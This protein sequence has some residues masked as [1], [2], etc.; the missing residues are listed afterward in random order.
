MKFKRIFL[1]L[2]LASCVFAQNPQQT[3]QQYKT[4][5]EAGWSSGKLQIAKAYY[6]S[7]DA[8]AFMAIYDGNVLVSWGEVSR[9]FMCHSIRKS[10]LSGL[11]GVY[12]A[13]GKID[14]DKTLADL[15]ID[16][17]DKL[18]DVEKQAK[19]RDLLKARSGVY[20]S[21]AYETAGMRR[22]RPKRDS[23]PPNTFWYY[24]NWDFNTAGAIFEKET[25]TDIFVAFKNRI[26][27]PLQM[28]DYRVSDGY[29]H[30]EAHNSIYPAYPFRMSAQDMARYGL[31]F[32]RAGR[33]NDEQIIS[34]EWIK[35]STTSYSEASEGGYG[36]MWWIEGPVKAPGMYFALGA[37]GHVIGV[38][39]EENLVII[40]RVNTYVGDRV[41]TSETLE[42]VAKI[43]SAKISEPNPNPEL[44]ALEVPSKS[45][46]FVDLD[47]RTLDM[48]V[49]EYEFN[50]Q[51]MSVKKSGHGLLVDVPSSGKFTISPLSRTKFF[52]EDSERFLIFELDES[53]KPNRLTL[54][55]SNSIAD[56]YQTIADKGIAA[57]VKQYHAMSNSQSHFF[58]E[59]E[60][61]R[62]G[63]QLLGVNRV[64]DAIEIFK[65]NVKA[66]TGAFNTYDSLGEAYMINKQYELATKN[67]KKSLEL[68]PNNVNAEEMLKKMNE[69]VSTKS[70]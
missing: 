20:H 62:L 30:L 38:V 56:L 8:A 48:Y 40:M 10:F 49:R 12:V 22:R 65:L 46:S 27:D 43:R 60:L 31:L 57:A 70:Q 9:R 26:A 15:N 18:T 11:Y 25:G 58:S 24:N 36:Y 29:H 59:S 35:E 7:L 52:V 19:V 39:Q 17:K 23:H 4:P 44:V 51:T 28:Q 55:S 66:Y 33:W 54:H 41:R 47:D 14:L 45:M 21:A 16:D 3:W 61:N 50:N 68:S 1:L 6:D 32:L 42:L 63:Y 2:F 69:K 53:G 37:G 67:F 64:T 5:E 13:E 34:K